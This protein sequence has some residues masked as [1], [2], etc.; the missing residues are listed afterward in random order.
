MTSQTTVKTLLILGATGDL[1]GRLLLPGL[2]RLGAKGRAGGLQLVGAGSEPWTQE[3]WLER[4]DKA[5]ADALSGADA[6]GKA[7]LERVRESTRYAQA[8]VTAEGELAA[9]LA[10]LEGPVAVYFALPPQVSEKACQ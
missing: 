6:G 4:I 2:A 3:Q 10:S 7:E 1:T 5:F 8:D 9:L